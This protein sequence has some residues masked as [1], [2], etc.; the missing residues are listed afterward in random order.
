MLAG[1]VRLGTMRSDAN[2]RNPEPVRPPQ[3]CSRCNTWDDQR[4]YSGVFHN[5][6]G[7]FNPFP[8]RV[9][10][11][12]VIERASRPAVNMCHLG[13]IDAVLGERP[14]NLRDVVGIIYISSG[15]ISSHME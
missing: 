3:I 7:S 14:G 2:R 11:K 1:Y 6:G 12:A 5:F 8:V 15:A 13:R 9:D 10:S 4:S